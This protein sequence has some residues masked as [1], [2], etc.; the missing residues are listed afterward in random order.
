MNKYE[1]IEKAIMYATIHHR[2]ASR[3]GKNIPYIIHPLEAMSIVSS[4][5]DDNELIAAAALHD[6]I[7]D[8]DVTYDDIKTEFGERIADIVRMESDNYLPDY[9]KANWKETKLN[10]LI[11]LKNSPIDCKIVA[12]GDKLSNIRAIHNDYLLVGDD[13]WNRFNE[14]NP[15]SHKWRYTELLKCFDELNNTMAYRE[16][17]WLVLDTF[18]GID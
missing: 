9:H 18:K 1:L 11:R 17:E 7:E 3:K 14:K 8:T 5:T 4:I 13:L 16:F 12:L 6:L 10:A 15:K 2:N